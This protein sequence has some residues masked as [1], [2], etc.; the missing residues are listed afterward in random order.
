MLGGRPDVGQ[1]TAQAERDEK[2]KRLQVL[3]RERGGP[4][5]PDDLE[6]GQ[7]PLVPQVDSQ[8]SHQVGQ[9][10]D[11]L[12]SARAEVERIFRATRA[13]QKGREDPVH[14]QQQDQDDG[15][16]LRQHSER[17]KQEDHHQ[18]NATP[19]APELTEGEGLGQKSEVSEES[20]ED[21]LAS[22][23]PAHGLYVDGQ[24]AVEGRSQTGKGK[25]SRG[26]QQEEKQQDDISRIE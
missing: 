12:A 1:G 15:A 13:S 26:M 11:E 9:K 18:E 25:R 8:R 20:R 16:E 22:H 14:S 23:D 5:L 2:G 6:G 21:V 19:P 4:A 10:A 3:E 7:D 17:T 24:G